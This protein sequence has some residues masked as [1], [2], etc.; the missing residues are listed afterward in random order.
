[1]SFAGDIEQRLGT[2]LWKPRP[3]RRTMMYVF[4]SNLVHCSNAL[5]YSYLDFA[6][7]IVATVAEAILGCLTINLEL[8]AG[9][10]Q[11]PQNLFSVMTRLGRVSY[12]SALILQKLATPGLPSHADATEWYL[13]AS[14]EYSLERI[15]S[16][17]SFELPRLDACFV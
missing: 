3:S 14:R 9:F 15:A 17:I 4:G 5:T 1:M 8:D 6:I 2:N 16:T 12:S 7:L 11:C 10:W 13:D